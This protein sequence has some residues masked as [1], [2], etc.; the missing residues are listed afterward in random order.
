MEDRLLKLLDT[1]QLSSSKF[2]DVIGVQR[3]S[4]SH[5]LT[6]R[7]KPS[8][9][10][11]QKTLKAFPMLNADWLILGEGEMYEGERGPGGGSLF[12]L[13]TP[14]SV[15]RDEGASQQGSPGE[16][17]PR[18]QAAHDQGSSRMDADSRQV[19]PGSAAGTGQS[20]AGTDPQPAGA[21]LQQGKT[22]LHQQGSDLEQAGYDPRQAGSVPEEA[23]ADLHQSGSDLHTEGA[24]SRQGGDA[25]YQSGAARAGASSSAAPPSGL[26]SRGTLPSEANIQAVSSKPQR[27]VRRV[28]LFYDDNS[29]DAYEQA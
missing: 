8:F 11:L 3:S 13:P 29:F 5:I 6:G 24:D 17:S 12:D 21:D 4:V 23:G 14:A 27:R 2:A 25:P 15:R 7:N 16:R 26:Q 9:D 1:E 18:V 28:I 19:E 22:A 10:F 20:R